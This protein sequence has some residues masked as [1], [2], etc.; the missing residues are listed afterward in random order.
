MA[1]KQA[2]P[3]LEKLG[4]RLQK[5]TDALPSAPA[6]APAAPR[7]PGRLG[8]GVRTHGFSC[9][10]VV[11]G[12]S[13]FVMPG[14]GQEEGAWGL[15]GTP[16]QRAR[17]GQEGGVRTL[18]GTVQQGTEHQGLHLERLSPEP[19]PYM[20]PGHCRP[21]TRR[22][23]GLTEQARKGAHPRGGA[24]QPVCREDSSARCGLG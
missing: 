8:P 7:P 22:A 4:E 12:A 3:F 24:S 13:L 20:G 1:R 5:Q 9:L 23:S 18:R 15:P 11:H 10:A 16:L 6:G 17:L 21:Q 14:R 2:K 19:T